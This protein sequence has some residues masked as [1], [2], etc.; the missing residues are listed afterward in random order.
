M[1][2]EFKTIFIELNRIQQPYVP[3]LS[4]ILLKHFYIKTCAGY[5]VAIS[6][7]SEAASSL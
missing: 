5:H 7:Q 2:T 1:A 6:L 4:H 3:R